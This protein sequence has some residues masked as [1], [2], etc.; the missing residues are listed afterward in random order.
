MC[1]FSSKN[2]CAHSREHRNRNVRISYLELLKVKTSVVLVEYSKTYP[3][4]PEIKSRTK[5]KLHLL[6][7]MYKLLITSTKSARKFF[8]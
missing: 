4:V 5:G 3:R 2:N 7:E 1:Y 8:L 6:T